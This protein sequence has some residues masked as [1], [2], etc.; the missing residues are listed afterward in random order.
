MQTSPIS[1][2]M[3]CDVINRGMS[4]VTLKTILMLSTSEIPFNWQVYFGGEG[5]AVGGEGWG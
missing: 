4:R 5:W 3:I 1:K 2:N